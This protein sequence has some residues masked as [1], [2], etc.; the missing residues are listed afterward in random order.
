[1]S[2][3]EREAWRKFRSDRIAAAKKEWE[4]L[5]DLARAEA[6]LAIQTLGTSESRAHAERAT[7]LTEKFKVA[8]ARFNEEIDML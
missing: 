8:L 4:D 2:S 3:A 6:D 7:M 5:L 1:M